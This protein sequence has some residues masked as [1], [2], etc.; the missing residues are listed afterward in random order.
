VA[1]IGETRT[2]DVA[3]DE[4]KNREAAERDKYRDN[5]DVRDVISSEDRG[6]TKPDTKSEARGDAREAIGNN[7]RNT[8]A[9]PTGP[10]TENKIKH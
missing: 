3:H 4:R 1:V 8:A 9:N 5:D 2:D 10:A 6:G 7:A